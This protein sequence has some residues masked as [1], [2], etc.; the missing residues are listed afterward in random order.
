VSI[1]SSGGTVAVV[2]VG[3][4][5]W[6]TFTV[7][8]AT[9]LDP[10][11]YADPFADPAFHNHGPFIADL[12]G[13]YANK[14]TV[15]LWPVAGPAVDPAAGTPAF[16]GAIDEG[17]LLAAI[18]AA[19]GRILDGDRYA[20]RDVPLDVLNLSLGGYGCAI[21]PHLPL[22]ALLA[23]AVEQTGMLVVAAAG[24]DGSEH[25][26]FPAAFAASSQ[27]AAEVKG[28]PPSSRTAPDIEIARVGAPAD[29]IARVG[30]AVVSVGSATPAG[31]LP[32]GSPVGSADGV[33]GDCFSN[34]GTWVNA[35]APGARQLG[36]LTATDWAY[37]SGTSFAAPRFTAAIVGATTFPGMRPID[38]WTGPGGQDPATY[39]AAGHP[40]IQFDPAT[41]G[42][43]HAAACPN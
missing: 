28:R 12:I 25:Y 8:P 37:W 18:A 16:E 41:D 19:T 10:V 38:V 6:S 43:Y 15:E 7:Q 20:Y 33:P 11:L 13:R 23:E 9:G 2:D 40:S 30:P 24:N 42:E 14:T 36:L 29:L 5:E 34:R 1:P 26:H 32:G 4:E 22:A 39:T 31:E 35:W 17:S 3:I 27:L 21:Y